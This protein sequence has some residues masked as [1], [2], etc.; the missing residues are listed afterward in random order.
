M[1]TFRPIMPLV[2]NPEYPAQRRKW[3]ASPADDI[4]D[5][6]LIDLIHV[7]NRLACCFTM[8]SCHGHFLYRGQEDP[9]NLDPL[10]TTGVIGRVTYRIAYLALC[11]DSGTEGACLLDQLKAIPAVDP[12]NIQLGC[13]AWFRK[14]QVNSYA[15]QIEP[16]RFKDQDTAVLDYP[17]A[18][19]IEATRNSVF[20]RLEALFNDFQ[21]PIRRC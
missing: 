7:V 4:L 2:D 9:R 6:P 3:L 1:E 19:T 18:L 13:P 16:D 11:I 21:N 5:P 12:G 17:E 20:A 15:I 14:Q 8:Q 10:P